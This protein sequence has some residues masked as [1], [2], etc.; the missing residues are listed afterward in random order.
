MATVSKQWIVSEILKLRDHAE[1]SK[2]CW[3]ILGQSEKYSDA[4]SKIANLQKAVLM[5]TAERREYLKN[6]GY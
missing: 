2:N 4:M 5:G 3:I 1:T 6:I